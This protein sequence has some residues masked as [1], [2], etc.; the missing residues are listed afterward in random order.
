MPQLVPSPGSSLEIKEAQQL[1]LDIEKHLHE[2]LEVL[3]YAL[4][5]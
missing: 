5:F 2:Q 4:K 3:P 1:Q